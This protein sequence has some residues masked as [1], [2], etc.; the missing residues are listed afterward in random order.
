MNL[1]TNKVALVTGAGSGMGRA[2]ALKYARE[3]ARVVVSDLADAQGQETVD[4]ILAAGGE[5]VYQHADVSS[6][7]DHLALVAAARTAFGKLDIAC[8]S[9]GVNF[10]HAKVADVTLDT[11]HKIM[12]IN[13]TGMFY[14]VKAQI[15]ALLENGGGAI[16]NIASVAGQIGNPYDAPYTASKHGVVGLTKVIALDYALQ[17]IRANV[18]GPGSIRTPM[19][20]NALSQE[21]LK[22]LADRHPLQRLGEATEVANLVSWLSSDEAGFVTGGFYPVD[23]GYLAT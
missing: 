11:W 21:Q 14:A 13:L 15:P 18:V 10:G 23:G 1:L 6:Y 20:T 17:N 7:D 12:A 4:Q 5:A 9:A 16:V 8:N 3:G 19:L 2:I 22:V